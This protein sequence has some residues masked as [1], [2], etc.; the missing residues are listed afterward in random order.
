MGLRQY[1]AATVTTA[2]GK[3]SAVTARVD[4]IARDK[5]LIWGAAT[6]ALAPDTID[7]MLIHA[8]TYERYRA[9]VLLA[10]GRLPAIGLANNLRE[11][12]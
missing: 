4:A 8:P 5:W 6:Y 2:D 1:V 12:Y 3:Q 11:I 9:D 7:P 10:V